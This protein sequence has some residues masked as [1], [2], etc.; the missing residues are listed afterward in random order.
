MDMEYRYVY[1]TW[2]QSKACSLIRAAVFNLPSSATQMKKNV[3]NLLRESQNFNRIKINKNQ[4]IILG[5]FEQSRKA[6]IRLVMSVRPSVCK[7]Q[8]DSHWTDFHEV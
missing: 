8:P 7:E 1:G 2:R 6:T 4:Q 5:A 3:Y